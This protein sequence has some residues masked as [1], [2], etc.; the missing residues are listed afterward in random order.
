M[1]SISSSPHRATVCTRGAAR[2]ESTSQPLVPP[3][4]ISVVYC[5]ADLDHVD[6]LNAGTAKGF[7]YARD[8]H[9]NASQLADKMARL[10]GAETGLV[11]ALG[12]GAISAVFL[13]LLNQNDHV[14]VSDGVYGKT[15]ALV[16]RQ[17]SRWGIT[18]DVFDPA[19]AGALS[20]LLSEKTRLIYAETISNPLLRIADLDALAAVSQQTGIPLV[21]DNTFAPLLCRPIE[22]GASL[23]IHSATKMIGGH[24]DLTLGV[25]VGYKRSDRADSHRRI[26]ARPDRQPVRELAGP[27]R[28]RNLEPE[29]GPRLR[30]GAGACAPLRVASK[31]RAGLLSR[32]AVAPGIHLRLPRARS[33]RHHRHH[34][35]RRPGTR[36]VVN[37]GTTVHSVRA[38]LG[39]RADDAVPSRDD[40]PPR[41]GRCATVKARPHRRHDSHLR[42]TG[43][44]R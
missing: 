44:P 10:E 43:T 3:I 42:G 23:V 35:P 27:A 36:R 11:C 34:R 30:V 7:I 17:L 41:P 26:D 12:M 29:N 40:Q 28:T 18:H 21:V 8:A 9:P 5:P 6:A 31:R 25:V 37:Q 2:T 4:D 20:S 16:T 39:R 38:E 13:S 19:D 14:L 15:S 1:P 32:L 22:H 33:R 24:S